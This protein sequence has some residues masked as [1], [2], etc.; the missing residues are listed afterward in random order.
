HPRGASNL[1]GAGFGSGSVGGEGSA[2]AGHDCRVLRDP[3]DLAPQVEAVTKG[4]PAGPD[5]R[6]RLLEAAGLLLEEDLDRHPRA[7]VSRVA[8]ITPRL[9]WGSSFSI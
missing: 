4:L 8:G 2:E 1:A 3:A 5:H 9:V 7:A 6:V